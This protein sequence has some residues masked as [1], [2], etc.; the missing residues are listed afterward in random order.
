MFATAI[1]CMDGRTQ[2]PVIEWMKRE[3]GVDYVDTITEPGPVRILAEAADAPALESI[4]RRLT[5]S[6][7]KHGSRRVAIVAHTDCAGN[8]VDK[9]TQ[10]SQ[11]RAAAATVLSWGMDVQVDMLWLGEGW[12]VER[13]G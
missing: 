1:N 10:F 11:L 5:I 12:C 13:V 7:T 3:H 8:P 6:V 4:R 2:L 9:Q